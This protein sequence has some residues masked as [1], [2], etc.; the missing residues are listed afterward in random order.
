M[1][2]ETRKPGTIKQGALTTLGG[3]VAFSVG[4]TLFLLS[5]VPDSTAPFASPIPA[6]TCSA[7]FG[8]VALLPA[9]SILVFWLPNSIPLLFRLAS[10]SP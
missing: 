10:D 1:N 2:S 4:G 3:A 8:H 9:G 7:G 6:L 5:Y